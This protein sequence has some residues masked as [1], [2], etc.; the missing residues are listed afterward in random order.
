MHSG[1]ARFLARNWHGARSRRD[2]TGRPAVFGRCTACAPPVRA[3]C[4]APERGAGDHALLRGSGTRL[5]PVAAG[6]QSQTCV[7]CAYAPRLRMTRWPVLVF[8][9][10]NIAGSAACVGATY[11]ANRRSC[12]PCEFGSYAWQLAGLRSCGILA[13]GDAREPFLDCISKA[14]AA[15]V[16]FRAETIQSPGGTDLL[17]GLTSEAG[18]VAFERVDHQELSHRSGACR[19]ELVSSTCDWLALS[20]EASRPAV[21]CMGGSAS[22]LLC[23]EKAGANWEWE[24]PRSVRTLGCRRRED[25]PA[26]GTSTQRL[27]GCVSGPGQDH[28]VRPDPYGSNL[29]CWEAKGR[30]LDCQPTPTSDDPVE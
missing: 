16:P 6:G 28:P 10:I 12:T 25:L 3:N 11:R 18:L 9:A 15:K 22:A 30:E 17:V 19:R 24:P 20:A 26:V 2:Q 1:G 29:V 21:Q 7:N 23:A 8:V 27:V 5:A 13:P 14:L 4:A